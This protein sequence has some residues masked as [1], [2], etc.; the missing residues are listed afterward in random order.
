MQLDQIEAGSFLSLLKLK[1]I[2]YFI[3]LIGYLIIFSKSRMEKII[4]SKNNFKMLGIAMVLMLI[5]LVGITE[6]SISKFWS[7]WK[8][9]YNV[10]NFGIYAYQIN[11]FFASL[12]PKILP[13]LGYDQAKSNFNNYFSNFEN[14]KSN[15]Y[16]N[17]FKDKNVIVIHAESIQ[18][19]VIGLEINGKT[20]LNAVEQV[21]AFK[22]S[23]ANTLILSK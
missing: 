19:A 15:K 11:D 2:F 8:R 16:T 22:L 1:Q 23:N 20:F 10:M 5:S 13:L 18:N 17:I 3:P 7:Q 4:E 12:E 14:D 21:S 9:E 6:D